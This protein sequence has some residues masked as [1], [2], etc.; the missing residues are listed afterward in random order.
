MQ[1]SQAKLKKFVRDLRPATAEEIQQSG[2]APG[3][4]SPVGL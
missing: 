2:A 1:L 3:Y 4:A